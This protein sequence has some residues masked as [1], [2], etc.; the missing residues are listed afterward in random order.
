MVHDNHEATPKSSLSSNLRLTSTVPFESHRL[1]ATHITHIRAH[2]HREGGLDFEKFR[3]GSDPIEMAGG[4][5]SGRTLMREEGLERT[6]NGLK[7]T[8]WP[9]AYPINQKN[10]YTYASSLSCFL[11]G[12]WDFSHFVPFSLQR[13]LTCNL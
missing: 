4:K 9:E 10:Y 3:F 12:I 11:R 6:D 7:Q 13:P 1:G 8:S 2:C 5:K